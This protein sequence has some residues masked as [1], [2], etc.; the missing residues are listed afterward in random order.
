MNV[1]MQQTNRRSVKGPMMLLLCAM[2]WGSAFAV[3]K[4]AL[5]LP[6]RSPCPRALFGGSADCSCPSSFTAT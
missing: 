2:I 4:S 3:M 6:P 5:A 1:F